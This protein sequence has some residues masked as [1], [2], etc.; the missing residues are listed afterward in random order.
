M[1]LPSS[2]PRAVLAGCIGLLLLGGVAGAATVD[3]GSGPA[4]PTS[5]LAPGDTAAPADASTTVV[6]A[7]TDPLAPV[8]G[9]AGAATTGSTAAPAAGA[10]GGATTTTPT[11]ARA[12]RSSAPGALTPPKP[13]EYAYDSTSTSPSGSSTERTT[14]KVEAAGTEGGSTVQAVTVALDVGGQQATARNTVVWGAGALVRR[15][16]I[17]I[18]F[19]QP[20]QLEC[21]W[22]PAFAQYAG[23]LAVG[24]AWSYDTRC[25]GKVQGL[26]VAIRQQASRRVTGTAQVAAP[27]GTVPTWTIADDTTLTVTSPIGAGTVHMVGTQSL[28]PSLGL[29]VRTSATV[30]AGRTGAPPERSTVT[31]R[32]V[33]TP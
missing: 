32:L 10:P 26:D 12:G 8:P 29:P 17:T 21:A 22:Q 7:G 31:T 2:T 9:A 19:G 13:G 1:A 5:A 6:P 24:Q 25:A 20:Q 4:R 23:P 27:G 30:D 33:S 18:T 16:L 28:A 3:D 14:T 11:T 15:S